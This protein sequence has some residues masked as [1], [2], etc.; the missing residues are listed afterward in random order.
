MDYETWLSAM[1]GTVGIIGAGAIGVPSG[2]P[3]GGPAGAGAGGGAV[4]AGLTP[5]GTVAPGEVLAGARAWDEA[6]VTVRL[7]APVEAL[8]PGSEVTLALVFDI[9][10]KWHIYYD[11]HNDTGFAPSIKKAVLPSGFALGAMRWPAPRRYLNPGGGSIDHIYEKRA[12]LLLPMKV[13]ADATP[14]TTAAVTLDLEWLQCE[15][16]C[17]FGSQSVSITLPIHDEDAGPVKASGDAGLVRDAAAALPKRLDE[18]DPIVAELKGRKLVIES[19]VPAK[20]LEF[21]PSKMGDSPVDVLKGCVASGSRLAVELGDPDPERGGGDA[22]NAVRGGK[23]GVELSSRAAGIVRL[24]PVGG[25]KPTY[26]EI[27][28]GGARAA[29]SSR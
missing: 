2:A 3:G 4:G 7:L 24:E 6:R 1:A 12:T 8:L 25:G 5:V 19:K 29:G 16:A 27:D 13:P 10:P 9:Q 21:Y 15:D 23:S 18:R 17:E 28:L 26:Y 22:E 11:G 14:G 20:S